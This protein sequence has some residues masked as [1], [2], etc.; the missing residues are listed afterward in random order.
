MTISSHVINF[1]VNFAVIEI[2]CMSHMDELALKQN[3][4]IGWLA[5]SQ[6]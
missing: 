4:E 6:N 1:K 5:K 2:E 3:M